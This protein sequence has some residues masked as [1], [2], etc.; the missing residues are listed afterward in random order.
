MTHSLIHDTSPRNLLQIKVELQGVR[1]LIWRRIQVPAELT[2]LELHDVLQVCMG[3]QNRH[4]F[5]FELQDCFVALPED[6]DSIFDTELPVHDASLTQLLPLLEQNATCVYAYDYSDGWKHR[7]T[8]EKLL[9]AEEGI[10]YP[11][12]T[13]GRQ[14]CPP[15]DVGG[16]QGYAELL[17]L[18]EDPTD[19]AYVQNM[20]W[21][22]GNSDEEVFDAQA[23]DRC[24]VNKLLVQLDL[25]SIAP[26]PQREQWLALFE[27]AQAVRELQPWE[28][29]GDNQLVV[30]HPAGSKPVYCVTMGM[31]G[32]CN[33]V[34]FYYGDDALWSLEQMYV[35]EGHPLMHKLGMQDCMVCYFGDRQ[36]L[37]NDDY[38]LIK[39]L[40]L[41]P[42]G[43]G[44]WIFF[45]SMRPGYFPW[46]LQRDEA[47]A[48]T[49]ALGQYAEA[50]RV[51]QSGSVAVDFAKGQML[52]RRQSEQNEWVH[53]VAKRRRAR[54]ERRRL[55]IH[56]ELY[57][58]RLRKQKPGRHSLEL[59][60]LYMPTP[61]QEYPHQRPRFPRL[62]LLVDH[63]NGELL[64]EY[65]TEPGETVEDVVLEVLEAFVLESGR[66]AELLVR[67]SMI[68]DMVADWCEKLGVELHE[69][70]R[71]KHIDAII[72][73]LYEYI[74]EDGEPE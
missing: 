61:V 12:C 66:P 37:D 70:A 20:L 6:D 16:P 33:A 51:L 49:F 65:V 21:A 27:A 48:L 55:L 62:V 67:N 50:V 22:T 35:D 28:Q 54:R 17:T 31:G 5:A 18:L 13:R 7:L 57:T 40:E 41:K 8:V 47:Q 73:M 19:P 63:D 2:F 36:E 29:L 14:H 3:W 60:V 44:Q 42:R 74:D 30:L 45:R 71:M 53:T 46:F 52:L 9:P 72:G 1:P 59:E 64:R 38:T 23:F 56:D 10:T 11:V 69:K 26:Y 34:A 58:A 39:A 32:A 15:E 25:P 24:A 43:K 4:P 68:G